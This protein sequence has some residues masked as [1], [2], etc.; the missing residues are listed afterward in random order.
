SNPSFEATNALWT[1]PHTVLCALYSISPLQP[2][3]RNAGPLGA[4]LLCDRY[5]LRSYTLRR[6]LD[7]PLAQ[8]SVIGRLVLSL[9]D[10]A[11]FSL[12]ESLART[13]HTDKAEQC[14][15][16]AATPLANK[17]WFNVYNSISR[18]S[19]PMDQNRMFGTRSMAQQQGPKDIKG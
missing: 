7:E 2:C 11:I 5:P 16:Q 15:R 12:Q 17:S 9:A 19:W 18:G 6:Q 1:E 3:E 10:P 4:I 13:V 14:I 8:R